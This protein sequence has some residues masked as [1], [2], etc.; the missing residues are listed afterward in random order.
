MY[1]QP[2]NMPNPDLRIGTSARLDGVTLS[3]VYST[4]SGVLSCMVATVRNGQPLP[5]PACS[6]RVRAA[7][8]AY[9][10][11]FRDGQGLTQSFTSENCCDF[12]DKELCFSRRGSMGA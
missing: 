8:H 5:Y 9:L 3:V 12:M 6:Q 1:D 2:S 10:S 4:P 7:S 11:R